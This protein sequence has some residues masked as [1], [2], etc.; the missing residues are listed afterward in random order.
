MPAPTESITHSTEVFCVIQNVIRMT[1]EDLP[2]GATCYCGDLIVTK[3]NIYHI[4]YSVMELAN[5]TLVK[6]LLD[7]RAYLYNLAAPSELKNRAK[8]PRK[9]AYGFRVEERL[10][11]Y[12]GST[13]FSRKKISDIRQINKKKQILT[14]FFNNDQIQEFAIS[15]KTSQDFALSIK[16]NQMTYDPVT[17]PLGLMF[18]PS[19]GRV[20]GSFDINQKRTVTLDKSG[21]N[22]ISNDA[23][24]IKSLSIH[25]MELN[26]EEQAASCSKLKQNLPHMR[27]LI[28]KELKNY[29]SNK[30]YLDIVAFIFLSI[31]AVLISLKIGSIAAIL[32]IAFSILIGMGFLGWLFWIISKNHKSRDTIKFIRQC[33]S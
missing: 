23:Q 12:Q 32:G 22:R 20:L 8:M 6:V 19:I 7:G 3:D 5:E 1:E 10:M 17:D 4:V 9:N 25:L 31:V 30:T 13:S 27:P 24:Y 21:I 2:A 18:E 15:K 28:I 26:S 29:K 16:T 33:L 11:K 14:L